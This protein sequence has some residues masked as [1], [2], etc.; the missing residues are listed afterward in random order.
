MPDPLPI[1]L[2]QAE[3]QLLL[4]AL[5]I[6]TLPGIAPDLLV[7]FDEAQR[8]VALKVADQTL[9]ARL[10]VGW[11]SDLQH[12]I[13][14]ALAD[15]LLDYAH[16]VATLFVDT[17][18]PT[19]RAMSFLYV[20]GERGIY[21]QCQ[22]E[23]DV[24]QFRAL[25][26]SEELEQRLSPRLVEESV[27]QPERWQG[28]IGQR[29]LNGVLRLVGE[30][31]N[32]AQRYFATAL[33]SELAQALAEAYH[34]PRVVQYIACWGNNSATEQLELRAALTILQG[35]ARAFLLWVE[36]PERGEEAWVRV[37][38]FSV[39][40]LRQYIKQMV[41]SFTDANPL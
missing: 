38:L 25:S 14:P 29:V 23:P 19:G 26:G 32:L 30:D 13:N 37:T 35:A 8:K 22:P 21:E 36:E 12:V 3:L 18:L 7:E 16:P 11:N 1:R 40:T 20:F 9:R 33:P 15:L 5:E 34:A 17:G 31:V 24:L 4:H 28:Q 6:E 39:D 27:A 10:Y 2:T 41:P